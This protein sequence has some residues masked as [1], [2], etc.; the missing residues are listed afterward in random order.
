[1]HGEG[2]GGCCGGCGGACKAGPAE[3]VIGG[4]RIVPLETFTA[5]KS[6][7]MAARR[8]E[9]ERLE[10]ELLAVT[11]RY[12][13]SLRAVMPPAAASVA[14]ARPAAATFLTA[15]AA[16]TVPTAR[17]EPELTSHNYDGIQEYDNPTPGWWNAL[18]LGSV[19][20]SVLYVLVYHFS[21]VFGTLPERHA[22]AVARAENAQFSEL[23]ALPMGE[24]KIVR[25]MSTPSWLA[26]GQAVFETTCVACHKKDGGGL[27]GP[28][29]TDNVYKNCS[30]LMSMAGVVRNGIDPLMP[31]K[32]GRRD[33]SEN[34]IA[35]VTAYVA[36]LRNTNVAEG[37]A[38]EGREVPPFPT[39]EELGLTAGT[40]VSMATP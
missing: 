33:M 19:A 27:V 40:P 4:K 22:A 16:A 25:I 7:E 38:P 8:A 35:L 39:A 13:M 12:Q 26:H 11:R 37:K 21:P 30:D 28:N 15:A 31:A 17:P 5:R 10:G 6:A 20:F 1:M 24:E 34:D 2:V 18:F 3:A 32:G 23:A 36:S 9:F 29:L 14:P